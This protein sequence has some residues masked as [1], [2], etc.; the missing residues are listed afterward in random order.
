M[1]SK[2]E[3]SIRTYEIEN[4]PV[5]GLPNDADDVVVSAHRFRRDFVILDWH[6][7]T[8]T[9]AASDLKRAI[10]NATNHE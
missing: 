9:V 1:I 4:T 6:G 5:T 2:I 10:D 3:T 7:R 8:V